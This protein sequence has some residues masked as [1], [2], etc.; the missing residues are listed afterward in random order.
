MPFGIITQETDGEPQTRE[1][2]LPKMVD[3]GIYVHIQR[4]HP[5]GQSFCIFCGIL[6]QALNALLTDLAASGMLEKTLVVLP[7]EFGRSPEIDQYGGRTHNPFGYTSLLAGGGVTGGAVYGK[8]DPSGHGVADDP[9][10]L[11]DFNATI[12][13]A[14]G[15]DHTKN[16][17]PGS[18]GQ[19][20]FIAG[21]DT[22]PKKGQPLTKL[23]S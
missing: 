11:H 12:A 20:F 3:E 23:F 16:E 4:D 10:S 17:Q 9:V 1:N 2:F 15:V 7:T 6:D 13:H 14:L 19:W 8:S 21:K 18:G 22:D 5:K